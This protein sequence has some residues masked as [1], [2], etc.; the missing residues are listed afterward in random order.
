MSELQLIPLFQECVRKNVQL[1]M[2]DGEL[3]CSFQGDMEPEFLCLLRANRDSLKVCVEQYLSHQQRTENSDVQEM[4][5]GHSGLASRVQNRLWYIHQLE[6]SA[7]YNMVTVLDIGGNV[8]EAALAEALNRLLERHE[9]LRGTYYMEDGLLKQKVHSD[10]VIQLKI[11][12]LQDMESQRQNQVLDK[13]IQQEMHSEFDLEND[14][15]M[16]AHLLKLGQYSDE[17][18]YTLLLTLHHIACDGWS[19]RVL[20]RDFSVLYNAIVNQEHQPDAKL[21]VLLKQY[22]EVAF[23][24]E[25]QLTPSFVKHLLD[26]WTGQLE[27]VPQEPV[28]TPDFNRPATPSYAGRCIASQVDSAL[29]L[30]LQEYAQKTGTTLFVLLQSLYAA[31]LM[32]WRNQSKLLVGT[33]VWGRDSAEAEPLVGCFVNTMVLCNELDDSL[34]FEQ[35]LC[36]N[37]QKMQAYQAHQ[38]LP[39][40][41]LVEKLGKE[42]NPA[43]NPVFQVWFVLQQYDVDT[44]QVE[45]IAI[46][47]QKPEYCRT[48][49]DIELNITALKKQGQTQLQC[50]WTY[51]RDLFAPESVTSLAQNYNQMLADLVLNSQQLISQYQLPIFNIP[52]LAKPIEVKNKI[53][54]KRFKRS[55]S[56]SVEVQ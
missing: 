1:E 29:T 26:F 19:M 37:Q 38:Q 53:S 39:F 48:Q 25:R 45:S 54:R 31:L 51:A 18:R 42:R 3:Y 5:T 14:L 28:I 55:Q 56:Q 44:E 8:N 27:G 49:F 41:L 21:P 50:H 47:Q 6:G 32:R 36:K 11:T 52:D 16:R 20:Q 23:L 43:F 13:V 10:K 4:S 2:R 15:M 17:N 12:D 24:Q 46:Q 22:Q 35:L 7:Q 34:S 33:P 30:Q 40:E 9:I